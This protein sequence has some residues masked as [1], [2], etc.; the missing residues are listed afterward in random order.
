M[1]FMENP[2]FNSSSHIAKNAKGTGLIQGLDTARGI[3][4]FYCRGAEVAQLVEH[5]TENPG[6]GS[7]ILPLGTIFFAGLAQ[8]VEHVTRNDGVRGSNPRSSSMMCQ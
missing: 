6:V 7:S 5:R 4:V 8:S 1:T 2:L 3:V